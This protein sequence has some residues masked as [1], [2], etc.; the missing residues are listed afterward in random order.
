LVLNSNTLRIFFYHIDSFRTIHSNNLF[1][2]DYWINSFEL[3]YYAVLILLTGY[4]K[5]V[6][7][8]DICPLHLVRLYFFHFLSSF[9]VFISDYLVERNLKMNL[10]SLFI[11]S[12]NVVPWDAMLC[13]SRVPV[14]CN[15]R[16]QLATI[17]SRRQIIM[18]YD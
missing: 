11:C 2:M 6:K 15:G 9:F 3:W 8:R 14:C 4:M 5:N 7:N 17:V 18:P 1:F 12:I 10:F 16:L 13:M